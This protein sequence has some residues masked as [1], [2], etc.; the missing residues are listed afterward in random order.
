[1][2]FINSDGFVV[3]ALAP[4]KSGELKLLLRTFLPFKTNQKY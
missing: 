3:R 1:M 2:H 4:P